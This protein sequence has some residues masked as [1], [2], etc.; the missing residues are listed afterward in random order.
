MLIVSAVVLGLVLA[1]GVPVLH[2]VPRRRTGWG[3]KARAAGTGPGGGAA[4][5]GRL[6]GRDELDE[7]E[8]A[9]G[10]IFPLDTFVVNLS[11]GKNYLRCQVQVEFDGAGYAK[12]ILC[13]AGADSRR[14]H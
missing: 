5:A 12:A 4:G 9:L 14:G 3:R 1:A 7:N 8:A 13:A 2:H 10:A 11:G 6:R